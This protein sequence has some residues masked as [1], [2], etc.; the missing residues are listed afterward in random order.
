MIKSVPIKRLIEVKE[1]FAILHKASKWP[2]IYDK[3]MY[4]MYDKYIYN[5]PNINT[6]FLR[7]MVPQF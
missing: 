6:S 3:L 1:H 5:N 2:V 4:V 7:Q